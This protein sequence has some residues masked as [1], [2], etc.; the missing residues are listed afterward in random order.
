MYSVRPCG[1]SGGLR[2]IHTRS[3]WAAP[4]STCCAA[5]AMPADGEVP[6]WLS[7][8]AVPE[9]ATATR[10]LDNVWIRLEVVRCRNR[11]QASTPAAARNLLPVFRRSHVKPTQPKQY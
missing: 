11:H 3:V 8:A 6:A 7:L 9:C 5:L 10:E 2:R 1:A 4:E